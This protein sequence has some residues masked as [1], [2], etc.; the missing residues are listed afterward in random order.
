[1]SVKVDGDAAIEALMDLNTSV[2]EGSAVLAGRRNVD[3]MRPEPDGVVVEDGAPVLEA[4]DLVEGVTAAE[5]DPCLLTL[6]SAD[7]EAP[8][9]SW[10]VVPQGLVGLLAVGGSSQTELAG[11]AVLEGSP[12][13]FDAALGLRREGVDEL[14]A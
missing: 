11:Q 4:E 6:L 12:E 14:D 7:R 2:S 13:P 3:H 8:V 10:Q 9:V 5:A 1:M